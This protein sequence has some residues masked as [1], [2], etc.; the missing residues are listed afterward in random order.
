MKNLK[1]KLKSNKVS[2]GSWITLGNT[3]IAEIMAK[4]GFDWLAIDMEHSIII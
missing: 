2:I 1:K 3:S 4:T